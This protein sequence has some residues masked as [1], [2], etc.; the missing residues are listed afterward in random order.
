MDCKNCAENLTAYL[1]G[2]LNSIDS[3]L[4]HSHLATCASCADE[5][6]GFQ[7][8]SDLVDSHNRELDLH[9]GSWNAVRAQISA[10]KSAAS[11][12]LPALKRWRP[13]FAAAACIA[14]LSFGYMWHQ[15]IQKRTLDAYIYRYI[16]SREAGR[17]HLFEADGRAVTLK[18]GDLATEN[19]FTEVQADLNLNPFRSEDR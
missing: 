18:S 13:A 16:A 8:A 2:E 4:I 12:G 9:A 15:Q 14:V 17:S 6:R 3:A 11:F 1:D 19:P 5:L 7:Q 10:S